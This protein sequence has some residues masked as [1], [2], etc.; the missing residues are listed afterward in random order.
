MSN[1]KKKRVSIKSI[2]NS[3]AFCEGFSDAR[4]KWGK[5]SFPNFYEIME[6]NEQWNYERGRVLAIVAPELLKL[7]RGKRVTDEAINAFHLAFK[8]KEL[9]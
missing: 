1:S 9:I 7:K 6:K 8:R 3:P 2:I 4:D 5:T